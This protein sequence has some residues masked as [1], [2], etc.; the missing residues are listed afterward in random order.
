MWNSQEATDPIFYEQTDA[1][2]DRAWM[3]SRLFFTSPNGDMN[4]S[5][6][7]HT[8]AVTVAR[9]LRAD[10]EDW[11]DLHNKLFGING[12]I[13]KL[14]PTEKDR[15]AFSRSPEAQEVFGILDEVDQEKPLRRPKQLAE[16]AARA[17]G[18]ISIRMPRSVHAALVLEA[19][20]E[21]VS[22][23]QLCLA[24]LMVQLR[25]LV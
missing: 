18:A 7:K 12:A 17:N 8:K 4:M 23:N 15:T 25:A 24:K 19:E 3:P 10:A 11:I 9:E 6:A 20:A 21:G 22:L 2:S 16:K 5:K 14:F 1:I 13:T